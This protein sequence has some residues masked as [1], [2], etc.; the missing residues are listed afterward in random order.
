MTKR[1][2]DGFI[3][4]MDEEQLL[5]DEDYAFEPTA[6]DLAMAIGIAADPE[7]DRAALEELADALFVWAEDGVVEPLTTTAIE[8]VWCA[9]LASAIRDGLQRLVEKGDEWEVAASAALQALGVEGDRAEI[10]RAVVQQLAIDLSHQE[11]PPFPCVCCIDE[12]MTTADESSRR[13]IALEAVVFARRDAGLSD[14]DVRD[15][16]RQGE[17]QIAGLGTIER[18]R[19]VRER[20]G[21]LGRLGRD[22]IPQLS[23]ELRAIAAEPVPEDAEADE[24]WKEVCTSLLVQRAR[25][26]WN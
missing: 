7:A 3:R 10:A 20:L 6:F 14:V 13:G 15:A 26:Q 21:R 19:R 24:I 22:S 4:R 2:Y 18:R 11:H 17:P 9:D 16:L 23:A 25:P 8:R 12:S 5:E 1:T